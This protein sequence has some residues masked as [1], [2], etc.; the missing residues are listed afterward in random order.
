M[1]GDDNRY[2]SPPRRFWL[3]NERLI[4]QVIIVTDHSSLPTPASALPSLAIFCI[5]TSTSRAWKPLPVGTAFIIQQQ[6]GRQ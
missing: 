6:A 4:K 1:E 5:P 2:L 3:I